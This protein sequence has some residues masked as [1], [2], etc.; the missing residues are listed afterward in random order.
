MEAVFAVVVIAIRLSLFHL[1]AGFIL[2]WILVKQFS[3]YPTKKWGFSILLISILLTYFALCYNLAAQICNGRP[4]FTQ[5]SN[6]VLI[7]GAQVGIIFIPL[8]FLF[9]SIG[10]LTGLFLTRE[11]TPKKK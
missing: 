3:T 4:D 7:M 10:L 5:C 1:I 6:E 9:G 8:I 11:K 2:A